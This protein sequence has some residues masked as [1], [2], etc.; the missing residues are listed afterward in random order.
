M[1]VVRAARC[2]PWLV[3]VVEIGLA[4]PAGLMLWSLLS[5]V[6]D[7]RGYW[8]MMMVTEIGVLSLPP[9]FLSWAYTRVVFYQLLVYSAAFHMPYWAGDLLTP[10]Q[11]CFQLALFV[12]CC[13]TLEVE[14]HAYAR[15]W[16][17]R[18]SNRC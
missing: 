7:K 5:L 3:D 11:T 4:C 2:T 1:P 10:V 16:P 17:R 15:R 13:A 6:D 18:R 14:K 12:A 8:M 9:S